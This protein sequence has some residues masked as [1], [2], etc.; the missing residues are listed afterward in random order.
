[1]KQDIAEF[2]I[3]SFIDFKGL[4]H[5]VVICALTQSPESES[6]ELTVGWVDVEGMVDE[7]DELCV[8]VKRCLA[9]G[10]SICNPCDKFDEELGKKIARSKAEKSIPVLVSTEYGVMNKT[11]V[12]AYL[13]QEMEFL[14]KNPGKFIKGYAES[15]KKFFE[16][17]ELSNEVANLNS[18]ERNLLRMLF[19]PD[20]R[21]VSLW[22]KLISKNIYEI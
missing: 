15:E 4:E 9:I 2:L 17:R 6:H 12:T 21:V 3:D 10:V 7:E 1:M 5:K 22:N 19:K 14:K 16:M 18:E 8:P 13:K 11:L 20:S